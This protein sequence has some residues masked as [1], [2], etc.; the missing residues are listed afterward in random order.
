MY[1][2]IVDKCRDIWADRSIEQGFV[3]GNFI[4]YDFES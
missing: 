3:N 4:T 2:T 1:V